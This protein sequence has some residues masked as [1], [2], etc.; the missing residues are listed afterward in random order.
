MIAKMAEQTNAKL[1]LLLQHHSLHSNCFHMLHDKACMFNSAAAG[2]A[3]ALP[4]AADK[5]T[6]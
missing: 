6:S 3:A 2:A 4:V 5:H 1:Y